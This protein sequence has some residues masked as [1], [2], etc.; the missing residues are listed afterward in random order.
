MLARQ[1]QLQA[2]ECCCYSNIY[3]SCSNV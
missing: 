3:L 1:A 2:N